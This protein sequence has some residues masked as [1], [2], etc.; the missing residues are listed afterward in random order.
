MKAILVTLLLF[1]FVAF[2]DLYARMAHTWYP[3]ELTDKSTFVCDGVVLDVTAHF[4]NLISKMRL[5]TAKVKVL[6]VLKGDPVET[7]EFL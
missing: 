3:D 5:Y 1:M 2:D 4:P 6:S 7:P